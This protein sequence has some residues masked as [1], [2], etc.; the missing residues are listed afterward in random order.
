MKQEKGLTLM[1]VL[2]VILILGSTFLFFASPVKIWEN[3]EMQRVTRTLISDL[4]WAQLHSIVSGLKVA[5][6]FDLIQQHYKIYYLEHN[7]KLLQYRDD[8]GPVMIK[9]LTG[10]ND[11]IHF[12]PSGAPSRG[13]SIQ[14]VLKDLQQTVIIAVGSGRVRIRS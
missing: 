14:L 12:N 5:I 10:A 1:E 7:N 4:R 6:E 13:T 3:I 9:S 8:L 11:V 2:L